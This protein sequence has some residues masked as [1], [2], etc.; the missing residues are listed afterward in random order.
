MT[1]KERV[2][3]ILDGN[4]VDRL[5]FMP[6]T[7]M[8]AADT[9]GV[10]Y[11]DYAS[12]YTVL[13]AAQ[14]ET[15][16]RYGF[17][18]V[19]AISDPAREVCDLG[20]V[21]EWYD[22]QPPAVVESRAT[23]DSPAKLG[24][25]RVP[26]LS[27]GRMRDRID[28][29]KQLSRNTGATRVVEGWVEGPCAMAA[30]LRG[31]NA[32]MLDFVDDPDFV[33]DLFEFVVTMET[34]FALAQIEAGADVIGV[35]D[36]AASLIGPSR[37]RTFV[38]PYEQ[39]LIA[40]IRDAGARVRLHI[41]GNTRKILADMGRTEADIIDLDFLSP[42]AEGRAAMGPRPI[43][44]GNLDPVRCVRD[45]DPAAVTAAVAQCHE[46][47]GARYI[48][49]AGCEIPRGT[50]EANLRAMSDYARSRTP[51]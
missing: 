18:H 39:S 34:E 11:R 42:I 4:P 43:L 7:M 37:Y 50:P 9:A 51:V 26:D 41:C 46:A 15:A 16:E 28:A 2:F 48:V 30:D 32:L 45:G 35:G 40:A 24:S 47:A 12:D 1:G 20:G 44:L 25:L 23:L 17:D 31:L 33:R 14:C 5:P 49:G 8:F 22:D 38:L 29:V 19:S 13:A 10:R 27:R 36:A 21:I 6:I 3:S